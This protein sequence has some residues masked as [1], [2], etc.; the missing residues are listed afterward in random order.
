M[1]FRRLLLV[2]S[3]F[4]PLVAAEAFAGTRASPVNYETHDGKTMHGFIMQNEDVPADAPIAILMHGM[5]THMFHWLA[6]SGPMYGEGLLRSFLDKGY[7]VLALDARIHGYARKEGNPETALTKAKFGMTGDYYSMIED[8][9][10]DYEFVLGRIKNN[11]EDARHI[12]AVGYSMGAQ[13]AIMLAA[14]NPEITHLVT[15]VP[16]HTGRLKQVSPVEFAPQV[17]VKNWLLL[18]ADQDD[19]NEPEENDQIEA[20]ITTKYTRVNFDSGH[21]LPKHYVDVVGDWIS[22]I[23]N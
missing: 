15:M 18:M 1:N 14:R 9:V 5:K 12:V 11:F 3:L 4:L 2:L 21:I 19:Y 6:S 7:R 23:D 17:K 22:R 10:R 8:S 20:A 16:P 13:M